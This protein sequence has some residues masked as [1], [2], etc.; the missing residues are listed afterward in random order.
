MIGEAGID[1]FSIVGEGGAVFVVAVTGG[2]I[3]EAA[4]GDVLLVISGGLWTASGG[5]WGG[6]GAIKTSRRG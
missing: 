2:G 6:V 4:E 1:P 3:L 5:D